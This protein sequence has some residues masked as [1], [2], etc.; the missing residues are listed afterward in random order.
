MILAPRACSAIVAR[1]RALRRSASTSLLWYGAR[2]RAPA[3][4]RGLVSLRRSARPPRARAPR[5]EWSELSHQPQ[6]LFLGSLPRRRSATRPLLGVLV[7]AKGE[8]SAT[9]AADFIVGFFIARVPILLF[10]AVQATLLPKLAGL[11]RR[12][13]HDDFRT[14]PQ[15]LIVHRGRHRRAR[16]RRRRP[17]SARPLGKILFGDK[18]NLGSRRPRAA[19]RRQRHVHPRPHPRPGPDRAARPRSRPHRVDGGARCSASS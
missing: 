13:P 2:A 19:R 15:K 7:L 17:R 3:A 8:A 9:L 14:G 16:H 5:R 4:A 1:D 10:Q 18:F 11:V 12:G 6:L